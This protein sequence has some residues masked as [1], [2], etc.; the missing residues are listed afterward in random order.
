MQS[1]IFRTDNEDSIFS[2]M[3]VGIAKPI[4]NLIAVKSDEGALTSIHCAT[5]EDV[6]NHSG[7]YF[8]Y[9]FQF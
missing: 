9:N 6:I 5:H 7:A 8:E 3:M 2:K 1:N 4:F